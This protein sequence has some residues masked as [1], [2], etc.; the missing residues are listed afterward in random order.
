MTRSGKVMMVSGIAALL[1]YAIIPLSSYANSTVMD[2]GK[3]E[4]EIGVS[5]L[6]GLSIIS[7]EVGVGSGVEYDEA[8]HTYSK[9]ME[10]GEQISQFGITSMRIF[11][12]TISDVEEGNC[13]EKGFSLIATPQTTETVD[14]VPRAVLS[15]NSGRSLIVSSSDTLD[16]TQSSWVMNVTT[17]NGIPYDTEDE[18]G[19]P[20]TVTPPPDSTVVDP[21]ITPG[22]GPKG[23]HKIPSTATEI[24]YGDT[25]QGTGKTRYVSDLTATITYGVGISGS[26]AAGT[27]SGSILYTVA[28]RVTD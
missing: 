4:I 10:A 2:M 6:V 13:R 16:S 8:S 7:N 12:N 5:P 17:S 28:V 22:Y 23:T 14:G 24:V 11:C 26:Q 18:N 15:A 25:F 1:S 20:I 19:H 21:A 3:I 9:T 27:Y